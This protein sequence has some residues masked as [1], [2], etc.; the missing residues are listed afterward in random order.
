MKQWLMLHQIHKEK[1]VRNTDGTELNSVL[2]PYPQGGVQY[3][4]VVGRGRTLKTW[5][6]KARHKGPRFMWVPLYEGVQRGSP[7]WG[8]F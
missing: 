3:R 4:F 2:R 5:S 7:A 8:C 6:E 1:T